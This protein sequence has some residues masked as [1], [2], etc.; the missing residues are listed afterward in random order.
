MR[1]DRALRVELI[2]VWQI[3]DCQTLTAIFCTYR[4]TTSMVF[5]PP[6][7]MIAE[8]SAPRAI[9]SCA[10]P[11]LS[12]CPET[13][14]VPSTS[15]P[16]ASAAAYNLARRLKTLSGLTPYEYICKRWTSEQDRFILNPINQMRGLNT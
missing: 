8:I 11:T 7:R 6:A 10:A 14:A 9:N 2:Y 1:A 5:Q 13:S 12:Q 3:Q 4:A 16:A 15:T